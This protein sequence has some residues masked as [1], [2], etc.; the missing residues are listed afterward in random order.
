MIKKI[1]VI[2]DDPEVVDLIRGAIGK[3]SNVSNAG[4]LSDAISSMKNQFDLIFIDQAQLGDDIA[5]TLGMTIQHFR[6]NHPQAQFVVLTPK[7]QVRRAVEAA[8]LGAIDYL[9]FPIVGDEI[10]LVLENA[11]TAIAKNME[12]NYLR[13]K[14]WKSDWLSI[15]HTSN[16]VMQ[17]VF[18]D[19]RSVAPTI[20]TVLLLGETGT[21]K[22]LMARLIHWH[23]HRSN[24]PFVAVH[25]G[26]IPETLIESEMFGHEKGAFTGADRRRIGKFEMAREG[27]I[28]LDEIGTIT[29]PAQVKLLQVLQ[30]G[31]FSRLGAQE[32]LHTNA[33]IIAATNSDLQQ[34]ADSGAFRMDL[35]Y[36]L[37][38]FPIEIPPL[39]DRL[40]DLPHL[41]ELFLNNLGAKY[42]KTIRGV[43]PMVKK[44]L[45]T[46][47]WPGNL[48][49]LE[50]V[51]ERACILETGDVLMPDRFPQVLKAASTMEPPIDNQTEL[52]L[53]LARQRAIDEFERFYLIKLL[54]KH[55]GRINSSAAEADI[56][57]RQL[58]RLVSRHGLDKKKFR[59]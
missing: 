10:R 59:L 5:A 45:Q 42:G 30:D 20:A 44:N 48:R 21:G 40:E 11:K 13:D 12:L 26:A 25:C 8:K 54:K 18:E 7:E 34:M 4:V 1:L 28:F 47:H 22:G 14:F 15:I 9:I 17:A 31:T 33:R 36:R 43:H 24:G 19:V 57:T 50:N 16:P 49:E 3:K 39:R 6:G 27:T 51:L 41:V 56:T 2:C 29:P 46:Y 58:S 38:A 37:N 23:S 35:L 52:P 55:Q 32:Q 53:A